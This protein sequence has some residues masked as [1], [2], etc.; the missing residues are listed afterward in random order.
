[1]WLLEPGTAQVNKSTTSNIG[2]PIVLN[3]KTQMQ[4]PKHEN[5]DLSFVT[6]N[7]QTLSM[8]EILFREDSAC[9]AAGWQ[10]FE[11]F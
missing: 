5:F 6:R 3:E 7:N 1:M 2:I 9:F 4:V 8:Q 10:I 11:I